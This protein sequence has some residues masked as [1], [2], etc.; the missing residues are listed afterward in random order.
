MAMNSA[1]CRACVKAV[2]GAVFVLAAAFSQAAPKLVMTHYMP[3]FVSQPFSGSWGWHWTMNYFNPNVINPT[4]GE[5]EIASWYYPVIGPY[6]SADPVVLE[7]H[8]LLMKLA[9][10]DGVIVDW[11]GM[12]NFDDYAVNNART[13]DL[14]NYTRKAGLEFSLCYEDATIQAEINGGFITAGSAIAHAQQVMLYAETNFFTD[15]SFLRWNRSPVLLNFGPQYFYASSAWVS[16]FSVLD[17]TNQPAFF[18]ENNRL[19]PVGTGAFDWPPMSL[20]QTNA[21]SPTEPV[22]NAA[23]MNS[24]LAGFDQGAGAWP[25]F[26]SGAFPRFH[27]IYAQAGVEPS[28][29]YLDDQNGATFQ[30]TLSRAMTNASTYI[31][32]VTWNDFGE[33]TIVEPTVQY[34]CRDLG[35]IQN[36]RRQYLDPSF[37]YQTND[38]TLPLRLYNLRRQYATNPI[39]SAELDRVFTNTV[40]GDVADAT[41]EIAG[42]ESVSPVIYR[43]STAGNQFQFLIGGYISASGLQVQKTSS[44]SPGS[45]ETATNLPG[46][47]NLPFF[48]A[49]IAP[50]GGATFFQVR[51][52][53]P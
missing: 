2:W 18:T 4:N 11:Y 33:G 36:F 5:Q 48:T 6:D 37:P 29:G 28:F 52:L 9:G 10:I 39:I 49:P 22:L 43:I 51:N 45:W 35:V 20:S 38:L 12:D 41:E 40:A 47:T 21:Q 42:V 25:A 14:F 27:D 34:G 50:T 8:V 1:L 46:G 13:L 17:T 19:V 3:W 30:E 26:V 15:P 44:L 23:V 16:N 7:Y 31:Q 32:V 53:G 24:Y